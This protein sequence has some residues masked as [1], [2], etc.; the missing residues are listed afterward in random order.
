MTGSEEQLRAE[1]GAL[2]R[3]WGLQRK[4]LHTVLGSAVAAWANVPGNAS[5]R[6]VRT[7]VEQAIDRLIQYG[8]NPDAVRAVRV[9]VALD[10]SV[11]F[12]SLKVRTDTLAAENSVSPRTMRRRI[13]RALD[14]CAQLAIAT[15]GADD[16]DHGWVVER[17]SALVSLDRAVPQVIERRTILATV[18]G[19]R[20]INARFSLPCEPGTPTH[21]RDLA[22]EVLH[23]AQLG[24]EHRDGLGHFCYELHLPD[25]LSRGEEVTYTMA[26]HVVDGL[27][28]RPYYA[29]VPTITCSSLLVTVR[30]ARD[31]PPS[32]VWLIDGVHHRVLSDP[33]TP[34]SHLLEL[35][36]AG[37]VTVSFAALKPSFGYGLGWTPSES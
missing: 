32:A 37:E 14:L 31:H 4:K 7:Q 24:A 34:G 33:L 1:L 12:S 25:P 10:R 18:D 22:C 20:R 16:Q 9:A 17:I 36:S 27:P 29:V 5:D 6:D 3:G 13:E 11:P 8:L 28:I 2:C 19:L 35:N 26:F 30:F 21:V 23:G 15:V